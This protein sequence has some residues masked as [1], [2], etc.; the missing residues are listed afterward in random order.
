MCCQVYP[1]IETLRVSAGQYLF[2]IGDP[3]MYIF[4]VQ[5]G[6][7]EVTTTDLQGAAVIKNVCPGESFTSLL[8]FIDVLT[9]HPAPYKT[10]QAQAQV[11]SIVLR[12]SME[13]FVP[14][15]T[16]SPEL[17]MRVVQ[18]VMARVQRVIFTGLHMYLGLSRELMG[19]SSAA[20]T[21]TSSCPPSLADELAMAEQ[22]SAV[23][24]TSPASSPRI[25]LS[26]SNHLEEG[27]RGLQKELD[28]DDSECLKKMIEL[29]TLEM[30]DVVLTERSHGDVALGYIVQGGLTMT[31]SGGLDGQDEMFTVS[32]GDCFGQLATITGE[33]NFYTCTA[34][35][36]TLVAILSK[37][38]FFSIVAKTPEVVLSLAHS[39]IRV[40]SP[41]VRKIDFALDWITVESG[42]R[43]D[44]NLERGSGSTFLVLS[45]RL[46]GYT[47]TQSGE[48]QLCG[49]YARGDMMGLVEVITR[50]KKKKFYLS[51]RDSEL[52]AIPQPLLEFLK[53]RSMVVMAKLISILGNRLVTGTNAPGEE[54]QGEKQVNA[55]YTSI[56]VLPSRPSTPSLAFCHELEAALSQAGR[57]ARLS[58]SI[59]QTK[60]GPTA[61][62][63]NHDYRL[64]S[65]LGQQE[66]RNSSVIY[67]CDPTAT[68]WTQKCLRHADLVLVVAL[69]SHGPE[70]T[71]AERELEALPVARRIRKE[72]VLM[73]GE[74][75]AHPLGTRDWL[76]LRPYLSNHIHLKMPPRMT[77]YK[78]GAKVEAW[79]KQ[80]PDIGLDIHSDFSRIARSLGGASMGLVLGGGGA[81]GAA[82][83][84]MLRAIVE[85]GI[86]V[87]KVGVRVMIRKYYNHV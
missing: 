52:C 65:W 60:L 46:R 84:G 39:T 64:N 17:L 37:E 21:P 6:R 44:S 12:L 38:A 9:G 30:G 78:S 56:A 1:S 61:L 53:S 76:K 70:V 63:P 85:A 69:A 18:M 47:L 13:A 36:P 15:F 55:K 74:D 24:A 72:L 3:D 32:R 59:V 7:L 41:L 50:V 80:H 2:R 40:L 57:V 43:V 16:N 87:D 33:A 10:V 66:D 45:G 49:E 42:R 77:R 22:Y 4:V 25:S 35:Q 31:Q 8:S 27:V 81:R 79:Y 58:S 67:Q 54:G 82:H 86:P 48:R 23:T 26:Y 20:S 19:S 71:A 83:L 51:V 5:T 75:T 29:R 34:S 28:I 14:V 68:T 62:E 11:D 73:W